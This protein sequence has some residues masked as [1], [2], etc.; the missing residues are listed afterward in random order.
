MD[1]LDLYGS[2]YLRIR[3]QPGVLEKVA[4][5]EKNAQN[6]SQQGLTRTSFMEKNALLVG[7]FMLG[8]QNLLAVT[9]EE[10]NDFVPWTNRLS[11]KDFAIL[12]WEFYQVSTDSEKIQILSQCLDDWRGGQPYFTP[13]ALRS[14][15]LLA[16][17]LDP[18]GWGLTT[19]RTLGCLGFDS[20]T[21]LKNVRLHSSPAAIQQEF[22]QLR[23]QD[24]VTA[25]RRMRQLIC[26]ELPTTAS[27]AAALH[28]ISLDIW[29]FDSDYERL[30]PLI[31]MPDSALSSMIPG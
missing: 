18:E 19:W 23:V 30:D 22:A 10:K 17:M 6:L 29:Q 1:G 12:L 11:N 26:E 7:R 3:F 4:R 2:E 5:L 28:C 9:S 25:T 15:S 16:R 27:V 31:Q 13:A 14:V 21:E 24:V 20:M 8:V